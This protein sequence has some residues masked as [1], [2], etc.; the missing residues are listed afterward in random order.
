[1]GRVHIEAPVPAL[2]VRRPQA[3]AALGISVDL[4][5]A[6][7]RDEL[8]V[9]RVAGVVA[10]PVAGLQAWIAAHTESPIATQINRNAA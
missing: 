9:V 1:M 3:A 7:V 4:F 2:A 6:E 5:D 8:P 10:Y